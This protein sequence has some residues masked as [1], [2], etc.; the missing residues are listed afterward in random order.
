MHNNNNNKW[1]QIDQSNHF[2]SLDRLP[3]RST[4]SK[5]CVLPG[6]LAK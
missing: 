3:I 4:N 1:I 6:K 2:K 5:L